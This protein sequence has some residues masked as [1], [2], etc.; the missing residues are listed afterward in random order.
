M[1]RI[2]TVQE[3]LYKRIALHE[4]IVELHEATSAAHGVYGPSDDLELLTEVVVQ[5][6]RN[7]MPEA[8]KRLEEYGISPKSVSLAAVLR[9]VRKDREAFEALTTEC[10]RLDSLCDK[11]RRTVEEQSL[12]ID[13]QAATIETAQGMIDALK[14]QKAKKASR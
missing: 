5:L 7:V 6:V 11:F 2:M 10:A 3:D 9:R 13:E 1:V 8:W 14:A 12:T 4:K